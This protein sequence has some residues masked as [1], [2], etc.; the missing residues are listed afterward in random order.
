MKATWLTVDFDDERHVPRFSGHPTRSQHDQ[1]HIEQAELDKQL[2]ESFKIGMKGF[3]EWL[4]TNSH[5]VTLFVIADL[6]MSEEFSRWFAH[7]LKENHERLTVGCHGLNHRSWSAWPEDRDGFSQALTQATTI[8]Q[9]NTGSAFR[10]WFR[11]P[12]GYMAPW[13]ASVLAEQGY[14]VDSSINPSWL[15]KRKAGK[16]N[17]WNEVAQALQESNVLSRPWKTS[18]YLPI[19]GQA[20]SLFPLSLLARWN[21]RRAPTSIG[22]KDIDRTV[23]DS[24]AKLTT[25]YWHLLDHAR[26]QGTW[27]PPFD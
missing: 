15:V 3:E 27:T 16:G 26:Q 18:L 10:P 4:R 11:A 24:K 25:L 7:L 17:S 2:S 13:M 5:P 23:T 20:L 19:N 8:L 21:W 14:T 12:G 22:A 6:F 1:T 9:E